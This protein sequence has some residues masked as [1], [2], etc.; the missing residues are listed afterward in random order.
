MAHR[1][2]LALSLVVLFLAQTISLMV[3]STHLAS[4]HQHE[5]QMNMT[6]NTNA[7]SATL[8]LHSRSSALQMGNQS[9]IQ[10]LN[11]EVGAN[12]DSVNATQSLDISAF[13]DPQ[14]A[15]ATTLNGQISF[16]LWIRGSGGPNSKATVSFTVERAD[17]NGTVQ[18]SAIATASTGNVVFP[19]TYTEHTNTATVSNV[20]L[21][22]GERLKFSVQV[23]GNNGITYTARWG[24][25]LYQSRI[26]LPVTVPVDVLS[27]DYVDASGQSIDTFWVGTTATNTV[28]S[29]RLASPLTV[30][31]VDNVSA[32]LV[33][34]NG[35]SVSTTSLT[36]GAPSWQAQGSW[37]LTL[38]F[39][40]N[41]VAGDWEVRYQIDSLDAT[42][43]MLDYPGD[44]TAGGYRV[45]TNIT[46]PVRYSGV[47]DV[48]CMDADGDVLGGVDIR[49]T[50]DSLRRA[51][52]DAT[53]DA[54]GAAQLQLPLSN[55][56]LDF[57]YQNVNVAS[58]SLTFSANQTLNVLTNVSDV[59]LNATH[60]D[61][62]AAGTIHVWV[63]HP[64]GTLMLAGSS[65]NSTTTLLNLPLGQYVV[66]SSWMGNPLPNTVA[67]H[68]GAAGG[69]EIVINT[70]V[71]ATYVQVT[72][73]VGSPI[74]GVQ[75]I[76]R[77]VNTQTIRGAATTLANGLAAFDLMTD[78][79]VLEPVWQRFSFPA[80][81]V[82]FTGDQVNITLELQKVNVSVVD[83]QG[84]PLPFANVRVLDEND[85]TIILGDT[86]ATGAGDLRLPNGTYPIAVQWSSRYFL[87]GDMVVS[88]NAQWTLTLPI[89]RFDVTVQTPEG[90]A[91]DG[92]I[93]SF[94]DDLGVQWSGLV[95]NV[96][97]ETQI[98]A[99]EGAV[100]LRIDLDG[101]LIH[102]Q[103]M[104]LDFNTSSVVISVD[105]PDIFVVVTTDDGQ[106]LD[107]VEL[108]VKTFG[109]S[110][111][112]VG[113]TDANGTA[114]LRA[115]DGVHV[116]TARWLGIEIGE[117][118]ITV[119]GTTFV[120]FSASAYLV[121]F[122][123]LDRSNQPVDNVTL[124]IR[125][126]SSSVILATAQT[127]VTG[128]V[129]LLLPS[130]D[131]TIQGSWFG[132]EVLN[133]NL[134]VSEAMTIDVVVEVISV[135]L[136]IVDV[137]GE[138]LN[139]AR[140]DLLRNGVF[141]S[142]STVN[143]NG[144][145]H[146]R[147]AAGDY[148][149]V[150]TWFGIE[151]NRT[152]VT[153]QADDM[154]IPTLVAEVASVFVEVVD[155]DGLAVDG[156]TVTVR[157]DFIILD[158]N[159]SANGGDLRLRL[160]Y[161]TYV[162]TATLSGIL[163]AEVDDFTSPGVGPV[164]IEIALE[165]IQL[166]LVDLDDQ[167]L[168][169]VQVF[170]HDPRTFGVM[171]A[172]SDENGIASLRLPEGEYDLD[173]SWQGR[174]IA[175]ENLS[176]PSQTNLTYQ[177]QLR[178]HTVFVRDA[179]QNIAAGVTLTLRDANDRVLSTEVIGP[180]GSVTTLVGAG[181]HRLSVSWAG[182]GLYSENYLPL[183]SSTYEVELPIGQVELNVVDL[184][185][186]PLANVGI[187][188][189]LDTGRLLDV[190]N[191]NET[192]S[193]GLYLPNSDVIVTLQLQGY[194]IYETPLTL[195][196]QDLVELTAPVRTRTFTLH[197]S[198]DQPVMGAELYLQTASGLSIGP[199]VSDGTGAFTVLLLPGELWLNAQWNGRTVLQ[200]NLTDNQAPDV[201]LASV[202]EVALTFT[203][204]LDESVQVVRN[205]VIRDAVSGWSYNVP[206]SQSLQ[207]PSGNHSVSL[208]WEDVALPEIPLT[209]DA[210]GEQDLHLPLTV[211]QLDFL[212]LDKSS[213]STD[214][215]VRVAQG[216]WA[217]MFST[218]GNLEFA[219]PPGTVN[220]QV[221]LDDV[222]V[223]EMALRPELRDVMLPIDTYTLA[224]ERTDGV[225]L[226]T[227]RLEVSWP[228]SDWLLMTEVGVVGPSN[229][230]WDAR[231]SYNG[232]Y[233]ERTMTVPSQGT[234]AKILVEISNVSVDVVD[235]KGDFLKDTSCTFTGEDAT[236]T[237]LTQSATT[238]VELLVGNYNYV[239]RV[240]SA[241]EVEDDG[242]RSAKEYT[243]VLNVNDGVNNELRIEVVELPFSETA[244]VK[245]ILSSGVGLALGI[246]ALLG[247]AVALVS[248]NKLLSKKNE[249][250]SAG[251]MVGVQ[252]T[253]EP[254]GSKFDVDDLFNE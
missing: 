177:L 85:Q 66:S 135:E 185:D 4:V 19:T 120:N 97:G 146:F 158:Q 234:L 111:L 63:V 191:T 78:E 49:V 70:T 239:C 154:S 118:N 80:Q 26:S 208:I 187:I 37:N 73:Q 38:P 44:A 226:Q 140:V 216:V 9:T 169:E 58:E 202:H 222:L 100:D 77:D 142:T 12:D 221:Y 244:Q 248:L 186:K 204:P 86:N 74:E 241:G 64:N 203:S 172:Q 101:F 42:R 201:L 83:V 227:E 199:S 224:I 206:P 72:D 94:T 91:I 123:A 157:D 230:N 102:N 121:S 181:V 116:L 36:T 159:I 167:P 143:A 138:V 22:A 194:V 144:R 5:A 235:R 210:S 8:Y 104:T 108:Q 14:F 33:S 114:T 20:Q 182:L 18:G 156:V 128:Q 197:D 113:L 190:V 155:R 48:N 23:S 245:G 109:D 57:V 170:A 218:S 151:V 178:E 242:R 71:T 115:P 223:K 93:V 189:R 173:F 117:M 69:S 84:N 60:A 65:F 75:L 131:Y 205:V 150:V 79:Y 27:N 211:M 231:I 180:S 11:H 35:T 52:L 56:D 188:I 152:A 243:G 125:K 249:A 184:D 217:D 164:T 61:G 237:V 246:A 50:A 95:T 254:T 232:W 229:V 129:S 76:A 39:N 252:P 53:C 153:F 28:L 171:V 43:W 213:L 24:S 179:D 10:I 162:A 25:T 225:Q 240:P 251:P 90:D 193:A 247:W 103:T 200:Q 55:L 96:T 215:V 59:V 126:A 54:S 141:A 174:I 168:S 196:G 51:D 132:I 220:M 124:L 253:N 166:V 68:H 214:V 183:A 82:E 112:D 15:T 92:A 81:T 163:V 30:N 119:A 161:G 1:R 127:D 148:T 110:I 105:M 89:G 46:V 3:V 137:E 136:N 13:L 175:S 41:T 149:A 40:A 99:P 98:R 228:G 29:L 233:F 195:D 107:A 7:D 47:L 87:M 134:T 45:F 147:V 32:E 67:T 133:T 219:V 17:A 6:S 207:L 16:A 250:P 31:H 145:A 198:V 139:G 106:V 130:G 176:V 238:S 2:T 160:P 122:N 236:T 34:P 62:R 209:V 21:S 165:Q 212:R 192:G 88:P